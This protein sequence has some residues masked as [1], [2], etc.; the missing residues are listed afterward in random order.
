MLSKKK[1]NIKY[2]KNRTTAKRSK[3]SEIEPD[4]NVETLKHLVVE[5][6]QTKQCENETIIVY[7]D[8][9]KFFSGYFLINQLSFLFIDS[10]ITTSSN[11]NNLFIESRTA[12]PLV[13]PSNITRELP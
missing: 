7:D 13:S 8:S 11:S 4:T 3:L 12:G 2:Y 10:S 5:K 9:S 6:P 1:R